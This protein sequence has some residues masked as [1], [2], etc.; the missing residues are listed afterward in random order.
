MHIGGKDFKCP[1]SNRFIAT[2]DPLNLHLVM[3]RH[4]IDATGRCKMDYVVLSGFH[5]LTEHNDGVRLQEGALPI[6]ENWKTYSAGSD[7]DGGVFSYGIFH[8]AFSEALWNITRR[9]VKKK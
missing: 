7:M 3:D 2:N 4:F 5:A 1:K 8:R 9:K 6:I